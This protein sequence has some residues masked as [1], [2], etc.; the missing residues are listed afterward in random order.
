MSRFLTKA[1]GTNQMDS[2]YPSVYDDWV[3]QLNT[4]C[5]FDAMVKPY[6]AA[7]G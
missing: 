7:A 6:V 5:G 1:D 2:R 3:L 4:T